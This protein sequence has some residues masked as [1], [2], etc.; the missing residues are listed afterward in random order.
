[1][2]KHIVCGYSENDSTNHL[3]N[4]S[5]VKFIPNF[6]KLGN[7]PTLIVLDVLTDYN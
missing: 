5:F 1:M 6:E 4:V 2:F 3:Q 7:L